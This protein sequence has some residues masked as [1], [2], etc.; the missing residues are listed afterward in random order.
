MNKEP[1]GQFLIKVSLFIIQPNPTSSI[2]VIEVCHKPTSQQAAYSLTGSLSLDSKV[3]GT[4]DKADKIR[5]L[6]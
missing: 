1:M 2:T 5:V 3:D 6:W 4:Q